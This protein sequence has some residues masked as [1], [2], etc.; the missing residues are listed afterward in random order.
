MKGAEKKAIEAVGKQYAVRNSV[1]SERDGRSSPD[2]ADV[3]QLTGVLERRSTPTT[4]TLSSGEDVE[5]DLEIR[6]VD[7]EPNIIGQGNSNYP[8]K[9]THPNGDA[10]EVVDTIP[11]DGGVTLIT[12]VPD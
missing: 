3:G 8:T 4:V 5:I 6:A 12:V 2:Y 1:G 11:E 10:F 9:L 7:P